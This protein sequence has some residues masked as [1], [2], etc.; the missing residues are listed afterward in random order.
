M[1][2]LM[3]WWGYALIAALPVLG[4]ALGARWMHWQHRLKS[5]SPE[6]PAVGAETHPGF[7]TQIVGAVASMQR[8]LEELAERQDF[9]ERLLAERRPALPANREK[10]DTPV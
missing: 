10:V 1:F 9:A 5:Q 6:P 8:Q 7:E 4:F 2:P 3:E